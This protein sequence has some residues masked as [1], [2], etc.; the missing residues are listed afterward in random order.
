M[1]GLLACVCCKLV[2]VAHAL[3]CDTSGTSYTPNTSSGIAGHSLSSSLAAA[4]ASAPPAAAG[5][6]VSPGISRLHAATH[7]C[8]R[9][10]VCVRACVRAECVGCQLLG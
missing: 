7:V 5:A 2:C 9:V 6:G 3:T 4:A 1:Q 8:V 10:C